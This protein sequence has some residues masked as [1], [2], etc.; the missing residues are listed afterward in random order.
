MLVHQEAHGMTLMDIHLI[1]PQLS[2]LYQVELLLEPTID[3][4]SKPE[5]FMVGDLKYHQQYQQVGYHH[6]C[7]HLQLQHQEQ[8]SQ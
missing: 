1:Q 6:K 7:L 2:I 3:S 4:E 8:T 5:T